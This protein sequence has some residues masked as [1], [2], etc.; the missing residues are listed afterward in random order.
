MKS[1]PELRKVLRKH[2]HLYRNLATP[3]HA[4]RRALGLNSNEGI[5]LYFEELGAVFIAFP[6]N[7]NSTVNALIFERL[8]LSDSVPQMNTSE[9]QSW[10][11]LYT[12]EL[13]EKIDTRYRKDFEAFNY[14]KDIQA[15]N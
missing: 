11:S 5:Y 10:K 9:T 1:V 13:A 14:P 4:L 12:N 2:P 3:Y 7:A 8:G 15:F 6:K